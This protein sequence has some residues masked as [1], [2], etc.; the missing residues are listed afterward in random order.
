M[1]MTISIGVTTLIWKTGDGFQGET[2]EALPYTYRIG[3]TLNPDYTFEMPE[4]LD[5]TQETMI[6][7]AVEAWKI[8]NEK[9]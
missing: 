8:Q 7:R 4:G 3:I 9:L 1:E 5:K 6:E 2:A